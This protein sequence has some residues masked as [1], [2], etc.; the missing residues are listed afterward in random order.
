MGRFVSHGHENSG[1]LCKFNHKRVGSDIACIQ[2]TFSFNFAKA[3]E[4]PLSVFKAGL[5][6]HSNPAPII[7]WDDGRCRIAK[8]E[9]GVDLVLHVPGILPSGIHV[10]FSLVSFLILIVI[11]INYSLRWR[12]L[13]E[14]SSL[15]LEKVLI[16][17]NGTTL[18][19][20]FTEL[21]K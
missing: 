8:S 5:Q 1:V 12:N 16:R 14:L 9:D 20:M 15:S 13:E 4:D 18:H 21:T 3:V 11:R 10:C 19:P 2:V 7:T 6:P 17:I